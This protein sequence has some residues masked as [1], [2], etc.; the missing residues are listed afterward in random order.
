MTRPAPGVRPPSPSSPALPD[1]QEVE[2]ALLA[3][4]G[5]TSVPVLIADVTKVNLDHRAAFV[6]RFLDGM[7]TVD[8]VLDASGLPRIEAL[9]LLEALLAGNV[10]AMK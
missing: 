10:I 5:A 8:D 3:R 9:R 2:R 1:P 6:L 4:L 7:S